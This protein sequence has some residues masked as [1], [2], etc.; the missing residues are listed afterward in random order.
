[1]RGYLWR[2]CWCLWWCKS[3]APSSQFWFSRGHQVE[4]SPWKLN[5]YLEIEDPGCVDRWEGEESKSGTLDSHPVKKKKKKKMSHL[6]FGTFT[7]CQAQFIIY[8]AP[9][10]LLL[11]IFFCQ[12]YLHHF[13]CNKIWNKVYSFFYNSDVIWFQKFYRPKD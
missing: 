6:Q 13:F 5:R 3:R 2:A 1:M 4:F 9:F 8:F 12:H 7:I 11:Y 10:L